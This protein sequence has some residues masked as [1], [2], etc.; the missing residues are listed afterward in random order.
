MQLGSLFLNTALLIMCGTEER[1]DEKFMDL[2]KITVDE[3]I[4]VLC[5]Y[6]HIR[7]FG[8]HKWMLQFKF[9]MDI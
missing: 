8:M 2:V 5:G 4:S 3:L 1:R 7:K 9:L 6:C